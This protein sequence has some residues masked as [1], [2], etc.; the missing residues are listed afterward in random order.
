MTDQSNI[1]TELPQRI[2]RRHEIPIADYLMSHQQALKEDYLKNFKSL[3]EA[4][5]SD[6]ETVPSFS[7]FR[8]DIADISKKYLVQDTDTTPD[9]SRWLVRNFKY[10]HGENPDLRWDTPE[11]TMKENFPTA[12]KLMQEYGE[13]CTIVSYSILAPRSVINRHTGPENRSGELIR[14]HIPLII[15]QGDIF[16]EVYGEEIQWTDLFGFNNQFVHSAH[17]NTSE[18]RLCF[19]IDIRRT[20]AGLSPGVPYDDIKHLDNVSDLVEEYKVKINYK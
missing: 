9:L 7:E 12:W 14:I 10:R 4:V 16:F 19:L 2:Y 18:W 13:D 3:E 8:T 17:N 1:I 5:R 15:P 20:R 6:I 11:Q